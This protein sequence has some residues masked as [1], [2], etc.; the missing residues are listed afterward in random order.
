[1]Y[2]KIVK[3]SAKF[4]KD[5]LKLIFELN[6]FEANIEKDRIA[7]K[8]TAKSYFEELT[9]NDKASIFLLIINSKVCGYISLILHDNYEVYTS[10]NKYVEIRDLF[11]D[12]KFRHQG[13][14]HTLIKYAEEFCKTNKV[15]NLFISTL[16]DNYNAQIAYRKMGFRKYEIRMLKEL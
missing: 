14:G 15:K 12:E 1:M 3:Y 4:E 8:D 16:F 10:I 5:L 6:S 7:S 9:S 11:I 13:Y 2:P